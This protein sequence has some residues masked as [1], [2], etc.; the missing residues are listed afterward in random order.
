MKG[1]STVVATVLMLMITIALIAVA[2]GFISGVIGGA[3]GVVLDITYTSCPG[4]AITVE[5]RN[6]GRSTS[7]T[8]T[9]TAYRP[10]GPSAGSCTVSGLLPGGAAQSCSID[11]PAG[12]PIGNYRLVVTSPG[13]RTVEGSVLCSTVG[14]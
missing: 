11:R 12:A 5:V 3:T 9:I 6:T 2:W 13:A 10:D 4:D 1:I 7:G 14:V 8:V